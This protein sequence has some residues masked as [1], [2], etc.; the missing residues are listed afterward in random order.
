MGKQLNHH[1]H[2]FSVEQ[3]HDVG[4][5]DHECFDHECEQLNVLLYNTP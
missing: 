4:L 2:D 1:K 3:Q 5:D